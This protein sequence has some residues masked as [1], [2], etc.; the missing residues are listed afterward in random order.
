[1]NI[2]VPTATGALPCIKPVPSLTGRKRENSYEGP[3]KT[4]IFTAAE[5]HMNSETDYY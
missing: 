1:M 3:T 2:N 4:C 5:E